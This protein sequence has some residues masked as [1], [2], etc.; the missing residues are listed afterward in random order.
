M[1]TSKHP[2]PGRDTMAASR[3]ER[4]GREGRRYTPRQL[5]WARESRPSQILSEGASRLSSLWCR[6][7][8]LG[9]QARCTQARAWARMGR[10][11]HAADT[12]VPRGQEAAASTLRQERF[13]HH[14]VLLT[15][16]IQNGVVRADQL[17]IV[18]LNPVVHLPP[19]PIQQRQAPVRNHPRGCRP[20]PRC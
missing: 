16:V 2:A 9:C 11:M 8:S 18:G 17:N 13:R 4:A 20:Q 6:R 7:L 19:H 10:G 3:H 5:A 12:A 14:H 15:E 1:P